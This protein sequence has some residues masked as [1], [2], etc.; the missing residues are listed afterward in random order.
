MVGKVTKLDS[1]NF[2]TCRPHLEYEGCV[3]EK[4]GRHIFM[5]VIRLYF[6]A[7]GWI[8]YIFAIFTMSKD[9]S[10]IKAVECLHWVIVFVS[11]FIMS[12]NSVLYSKKYKKFEAIIKS[13][14]YDYGGE[15]SEKQINIV[16]DIDGII[17]RVMLWT[18]ITFAWGL[19]ASY[20]KGPLFMEK[21][22]LPFP[23]WFP[24]KIQDWTSY[25]ISMIYLFLVCETMVGSSAANCLLFVTL[26]G[27]LD[28]QIRV[29]IEAVRGIDGLAQEDIPSLE[30]HKRISRRIKSCVEHQLIIIDYF[31][32]VQKYY[33]WP[34]LVTAFSMGIILCTLG[35][36]VINP[37][38][39]MP[40]IASFVFILIPEM[41]I[42]V[43]Y[44]SL[45]QRIADMSSELSDTVYRLE[46]YSMP[47]S[48]QRDLL[49]LMVGSRKHYQFTGF[50]LH[51][52]SFKGLSEIF[53]ASFTYFN[54]LVALSGGK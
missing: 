45:G 41:I 34:L 46:W 22:T 1:Q 26:C 42:A 53:Q 24:W 28:A 2:F 11:V 35:Y 47:V 27:H 21:F 18:S 30:R 3:L 13:G 25:V 29:L 37:E 7:A 20:L 23:L 32:E 48:I 6:L 39:T 19:F 31:V 17:R 10:V 40:H 14:F 36:I 9:E 33:N 49:L 50:N 5:T 43:F 4:S 54:M 15:M 51:Q 38:S 52:F 44:C 8:Q 12:L 16:K